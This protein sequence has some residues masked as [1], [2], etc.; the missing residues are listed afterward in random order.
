MRVLTPPCADHTNQLCSRHTSA[1]PARHTDATARA[2]AAAVAIATTAAAAAV[3]AAAAA[4]VFSC[5]QGSYD[6]QELAE[7]DGGDLVVGELLEAAGLRGG[8]V[9][10]YNTHRRS[11]QP[12]RYKRCCQ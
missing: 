2:P 7:G 5:S 10:A 6:V 3:T 9:P 4:R 12:Q 1:A 8:G 11:R